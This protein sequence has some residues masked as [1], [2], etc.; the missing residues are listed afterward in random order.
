VEDQHAAVL[1]E[2]VDDDE[3][4]EHDVGTFEGLPV[5]E[6]DLLAA[7]VEDPPETRQLRQGFLLELG[8]QRE[9]ADPVDDQ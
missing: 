1:G 4:R 2:A 8:E 7:P 9:R 3:P 5:R 6:E